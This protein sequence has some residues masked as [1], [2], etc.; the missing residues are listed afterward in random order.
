MTPKTSPKL[1]TQVLIM[2][3]IFFPMRINN[4]VL[5]GLK[6][7]HACSIKD[8]EK[9]FATHWKEVT[10]HYNSERKSE[11]EAFNEKTGRNDQAKFRRWKMTHPAVSKFCGYFDGEK[12]IEHSGWAEED[13]KE[14]LVKSEKWGTYWDVQKKNNSR[15]TVNVFNLGDSGDFMQI[16]LTGIGEQERSYFQTLKD[17]VFKKKREQLAKYSEAQNNLIN[18][19]VI[20]EGCDNGSGSETENE[21]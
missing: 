13:Y 11:V 3:R 14:V 15:S 17:D 20:V 18:N 21:E 19:V 2:A 16:D 8:N 6:I 10:D 7:Q 12:G 9:K 4:T 5:L 1:L